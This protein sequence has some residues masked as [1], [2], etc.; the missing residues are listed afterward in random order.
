MTSIN[1]LD[2]KK[3]SAA[4]MVNG[5]ADESGNI[6]NRVQTPFLIPI[7][8]R[9]YTW[10]I[11]HVERLMKDLFMA[12]KDNRRREYFIGAIVVINNDK[13]HALELIDGQQR[14]TTLWLLASLLMKMDG[15]IPWQEFMVLGEGQQGRPR[16]IFSGRK[17]D[18]NALQF[19]SGLVSE[20]NQDS[21]ISNEKI[22]SALNTIKTFLESDRFNN[23]ISLAEFSKYIWSKATFVITHLHPDT[24]K[25]RL[26]DTMN[27]GGVQLEKHE[28]LKALLLKSLTDEERPFYA[29]A[30]DLCADIDGYFPNRVQPGLQYG[31]KSVKD[32][33]I[34]S[35]YNA[36]QTIDEKD[37][38]EAA[39]DGGEAKERS[40]LEIIEASHAIG[41]PGELTVKRPRL[42]KNVVGFPV[43]LLHVLRIFTNDAKGS[44][45]L[46]EKKLIESF[47]LI[48]SVQN[49][50][51]HSV[52]HY[53]NPE[54]SKSFILCLL[55]CRLL[56]DNF[57]IKGKKL[58]EKSE[59]MRWQIASSLGS[60]N[61]GRI[62]RGN[63]EWRSISMMQS[64]MYFSRDTIHAPWLT[65]TLR[66]LIGISDNWDGKSGMPFYD[67]LEMQDK[68]YVERKFSGSGL[69]DIVG[70]VQGSTGRGLNAPRYWFYKLEYCL[71]E[72][73]FNEHRFADTLTKVPDLLKPHKTDFHMRRVSSIEHVSPQSQANGVFVKKE[74]LDRFGNLALITD[75]ENSINSDK[76]PTE[77]AGTFNA[78]LER[79]HVQSLKLG[80]IF[81]FI[82]D[83]IKWDDHALVKHESA[84]IAVLKEFH[85]YLLE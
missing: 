10:E 5:G 27:S 25:E 76:S 38:Y 15:N 17:A 83:K 73:W 11:E 30:W 41:R 37:N 56:V 82:E 50:T 32:S 65:K 16:L 74:L 70:A 6:I 1:Q 22:V 57:I 24:E 3:F 39:D 44:I 52:R 78:R 9:L 21:F 75:S 28:V 60:E 35:I 80:H 62:I 42:F 40:L 67:S 7:Y 12:F 85:P 31:L 61:S 49:A 4:V 59:Y 26:F 8:Q 53:E 54:Q 13:C 84:M 33:D 20:K 55:R 69:R 71:W 2:A 14:M 47:R 48:F 68:E 51:S 34:R 18:A 72:I 63:K 36:L 23:D 29:K 46:D 77:K 64:M 19:L 43:F 66:G 81:Q 79:H 58:D 45:S